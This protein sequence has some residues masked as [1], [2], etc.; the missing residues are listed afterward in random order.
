MD[1]VS[2][3]NAPRLTVE[4]IRNEALSKLRPGQTV[5][6]RVLSPTR[7]N[8][9]RLSIRG[10]EVRAHTGIQM[11]AGNKLL[12]SVVRTG[13]PLQMKVLRKASE[14]Q[15][16]TRALRA[17]LPRQAPLHQLFSRL[18]ELSTAGPRLGKGGQEAALSSNPA[19]A[20]TRLPPQPRIPLI[21]TGI[22]KASL[23][24]SPP[25]SHTGP[26]GP[27]QLDL[28]LLQTTQ[29]ILTQA[30]Q[31]GEPLT[32]TRLRTAFEH[33]GLFLE[34]RLAAGL[35]P[36]GDLKASLLQ[37]LSQLRGRLSAE[38][39]TGSSETTRQEPASPSS[40]AMR[41]LLDLLSQ[42]EGSLA[43][44]LVN[45]LTSLPVDE[46]VKQVW[47]FELPIRLSQQMDEF[48]LQI[49]C[50]E[51]QQ[52]GEKEAGWTVRLDFD[53]AGLGPVSSRLVL[54][55]NRISSHFTTPREGTRRLIEQTLPALEQAFSRAGLQVGHLTA[56]QD[57]LVPE[58]SFHRP[59]FPLLDEQ[60]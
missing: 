44:L 15:V 55:G 11:A 46:G 53:L 52:S 43:R 57:Q 39:P 22:A 5:E 31:Q 13:S 24:R 26:S 50:D 34:A 42:T 60:A 25:P 41:L 6:A 45:Q 29:R 54:R 18:T 58:R 35:K 23:T 21:P 48:R 20:S 38:M 4:T 1:I 28:E 59:P 14:S 19:G 49:S 56:R 36:E 9:V 7:D 3:I 51:Q 10:R 33:S 40:P 12:L 47:Q 16:Q 2:I 37:L 17:A 30:L 8:Q 32:P 27:G